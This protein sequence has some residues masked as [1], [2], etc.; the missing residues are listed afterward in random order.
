MYLQLHPE[1]S[2][3]S[4]PVVVGSVPS[5]TLWSVLRLVVG[6]VPGP[7]VGGVPRLVVG[8]VPGPVVGGVPRL[9][10]GNVPELVVGGVPGPVVGG[11]PGV[12]VGRVPVSPS[13]VPC[14]KKGFVQDVLYTICFHAL[15]QPN[16]RCCYI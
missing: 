13:R 3:S 8:N 5:T 1:S 2:V 11:V 15:C 9:V 10:V 16:Q 14:G 12:A 7:V 4:P 6:N